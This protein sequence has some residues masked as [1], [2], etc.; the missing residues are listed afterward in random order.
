MEIVLIKNWNVVEGAH[1][2]R[3]IDNYG[4]RKID[5]KFLGKAVSFRASP[6]I[7]GCTR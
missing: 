4:N 6:P 1:Y 2:N 5:E 7:S 3:Y